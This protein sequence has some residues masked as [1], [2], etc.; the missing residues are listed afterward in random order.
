VLLITTTVVGGL[1]PPQLITAVLLITTTVVGG[2]EHHA[3]EFHATAMT[4]DRGPCS[5]GICVCT[6]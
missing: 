3:T 4:S 6:P 1:R 5:S 2:L